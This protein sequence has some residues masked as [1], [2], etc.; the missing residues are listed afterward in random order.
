MSLEVNLQIPEVFYPLIERDKYRYKVYYGGRGG[1]KSHN[2][3]RALIYLGMQYKLRILCARELQKSI[4]DSVHKLLSDIIIESGLGQFYEI[5]KAAIIGINGTEFIFKGLKYNATEIKSTEGIDIAWIEEAEKVSDASWEMLIP[6]IRREASEIWVSF[7]TKNVTDPT[8]QRFVVNQ[9]DDM[10]VR[11]VS[12]R[13]NPFFP[14]VLEK[15]R[16]KLF[17]SDKEAYNH[18]W[19][20]EPDT[21]YSGTVYANL[22]A[23]MRERGR[24]TNVPYKPSFP[25]VTAWDLGKRHATCIWFAQVVARE[26]RIFDYY[27]AYGDDADIEKLAGIIKGKDYLYDMHWLP[28]DARHERLGMKG[29][30]SDQLKKAGIQNRILPNVSVSAG[31]EKGKALLRECFVD[32]KATKEGIHALECYHYEYDENKQCFKDTP[33]DDWSADAAD[34]FRYLAIALDQRPINEVK[35]QPVTRPIEWSPF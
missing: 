12:Y 1:A 18:V 6:T 2:F 3:A 32:Q 33:Y 10:V 8:Y 29:S 26:V 20:G 24:I 15:E 13:D 11:K 28:H 25:V 23:K 9:T 34:A 35:L 7:N 30:I 22:I 16:L 31:I 17:N 5:Q 4:G 19:E 14:D 21:R 27:E